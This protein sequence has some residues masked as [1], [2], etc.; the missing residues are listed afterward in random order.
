MRRLELEH[1]G[2]E[3]LDLWIKLGRGHGSVDLEA[4]AI[5]DASLSA[6]TTG[7]AALAVALA[8]VAGA[9]GA[10]PADE[11]ARG[12]AGRVVEIVDGDTAVLEGGL[13]IRL[14]GVQAP[15]LALG[16]HFEDWPLAAEAREALAALVLDAEVTLYY[17]GRRRD[18]HERALAHLV[19][20]DRLW[21]QRA[22]LERG[23]ARLYSF[24]DNRALI[25]EMLAAERAARAAGRGIWGDSFYRVRAPEYLAGDVGSFQLV[26]GTIVAA[27]R[28]RG[29]LYLNFGADW[30]DD[31]TVTVAPG[32][33]RAF[34]RAWA[35]AGLPEVSA[36]A[37][38]RV[39][40]RGWIDEYNGPSIEAS[41]PEQIEWLE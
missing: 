9:A 27:A 16:R 32:E 2:C 21:V 40:V 3:R 22:M 29:R 25:A 23:M 15:K 8:A 5:I 12:E 35:A 37:G 39:R 24:A 19:R 14:V 17:G 1:A 38:R 41:H 10:G 33:R 11:L 26:E 20:G 30:R 36:L 4:V 34:E 6:G 28:V 31:F 13:V 18:R 7:F